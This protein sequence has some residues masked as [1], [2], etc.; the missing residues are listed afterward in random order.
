MPNSPSANGASGI[1]CAIGLCALEQATKITI[2]YGT[3][4]LY[5]TWA[6]DISARTLNHEI[7]HLLK[8]RHSWIPNDGCGDTPPNPNCWEF[9]A[10]DTTCPA[11]APNCCSDWSYLSN[12]LM[13]YNSYQPALT[14]C[15]I[16][17]MHGQLN[18]VQNDWIHSCDDCLPS[19]TF[20]TLPER[21][22]EGED[23]WLD[24]RGS[25]NANTVDIE[26]RNQSGSTLLQTVPASF[27]AGRI[28][29]APLYNFTAG[30]TYK[31]R[32]DAYRSNPACYRQEATQ[33]L[34]TK[35]VTIDHAVECE[36]DPGGGEPIGPPGN[37]HERRGQV[38]A[39]A[40]QL[41]LQRVASHSHLL[42][43]INLG[44]ASVGQLRIVDLTGRVLHERKVSSHHDQP[45]L[46]KLPLA[47]LAVGW[48]SVV[49]ISQAG[50]VST[51]FY[52]RP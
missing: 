18:G 38:S 2:L 13:D 29:L 52:R 21:V 47:N 5:P 16:D 8:V 23:I 50:V 19:H 20:I 35:S 32:V 28:N 10:S 17:R 22:C 51:R 43:Q 42:L 44:D 4:Q 11:S 41:S 12:N 30:L 9:G 36:S 15:Q 14:P 6:I 37:S 40:P 24:W 45:F 1:A 7:A 46:I 3:Y 48:Y 49:L 34:M 39:G 25:F 33:A 31:I 26:I 27:S